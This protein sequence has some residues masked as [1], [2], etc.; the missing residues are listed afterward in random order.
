[1][2]IAP[3]TIC[4][5]TVRQVSSLEK[6]NNIAHEDPAPSRNSVGTIQQRQA[7]GQQWAEASH[8]H[9]DHME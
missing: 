4:E 8:R 9:G 5:V 2:V 3:S 6:G 1:M 7:V